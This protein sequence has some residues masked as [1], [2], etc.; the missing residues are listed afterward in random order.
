M[1]EKNLDELS[2]KL[3]R[4]ILMS[5]IKYFARADRD[6]KE[7][8]LTESSV[9]LLQYINILKKCSIAKASQMLMATPSFTSKIV[10]DLQKLRLIKKAQSVK[11]KR[12]VFIQLTV[13]GIKTVKKIIDYDVLHRKAILQRIAQ[14]CGES[15]LHVLSEIVNSLLSDFGKEI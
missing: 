12:E 2:Q 5:R 3:N 6:L 4:L 8:S 11:D 14:K 7:L 13:E 15:K 9:R 1:D 10:R